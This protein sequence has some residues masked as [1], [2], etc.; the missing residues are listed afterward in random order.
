MC[1]A[2]QL[3]VKG[4]ASVGWVRLIVDAKH[5]N[6]LVTI[7]AP[8]PLILIDFLVQ[9]DHPNDPVRK[10]RRR[11]SKQSPDGTRAP[12]CVCSHPRGTQGRH[13]VCTRLVPVPALLT[14]SSSPSLGPALLLPAALPELLPVL[15]EPPASKLPR[16]RRERRGGGALTKS[17]KDPALPAP[18]D[19]PRW[20]EDTLP[21]V[22]VGGDEILCT[23]SAGVAP[24]D[25][26]RS[27]SPSRQSPQPSA[28]RA[29]RLEKESFARGAPPGLAP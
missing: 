24:Y 18:A 22:T 11:E 8:T 23:G 14:S 2:C 17:A 10:K 21:L 15:V 6:P 26:P 1:Q 19:L 7:A 27:T 16:V 25:A 3:G 5:S 29:G 9:L 28:S 20:A 13:Y 12:L 4:I